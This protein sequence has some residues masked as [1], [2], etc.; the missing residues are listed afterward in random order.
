[1]FSLVHSLLVVLR[2]AVKAM[3]V[4]EPVQIRVVLLV[5]LVL[6][7]I[8]VLVRHPVVVVVRP[9]LIV[10]MFL[11]SNLATLV[12]VHQVVLGG[13]GVLACHRAGREHKSK[14]ITVVIAKL[15]HAI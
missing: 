5:V 12:P 1:M 9:K 15:N 4:V 8:G 10:A 14:L 3:V 7:A 11:T 13:L 6:L 2:L